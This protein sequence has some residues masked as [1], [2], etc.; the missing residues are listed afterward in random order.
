M[1]AMHSDISAGNVLLSSNPVPGGEGFLTDF[2]FAHVSKE[3]PLLVPS[4]VS[5]LGGHFAEAPNKQHIFMEPH[6]AN[7]TVNFSMPL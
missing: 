3:Y 7:I 5:D 2:D 1:G 4:D 6:K